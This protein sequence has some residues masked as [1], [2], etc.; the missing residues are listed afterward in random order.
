MNYLLKKKNLNSYEVVPGPG[1]H[2]VKVASTVKEKNLY[3]EDKYPRY[4]VNLKCSTQENFKLCLKRMGSK[5]E[6]PYMDVKEY[7][8]SG[9]IWENE[10]T[11][12]LLLPT[13]GE[14]VIATFN[15]VDEV[16]RCV[17]ITLIP[18]RVLEN[19]DLNAVCKSRSLLKNLLEN[20]ELY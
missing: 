16:L 13:K 15:Y 17:S 4:I 18:R 10:I 3:S 5:E 6:I 14:E 1:T 9:A 7:F 11:N 8:L 12:T 20:D 19:F 2:I